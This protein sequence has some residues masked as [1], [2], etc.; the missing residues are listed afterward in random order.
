MDI[1]KIEDEARENIGKP[2]KKKT[3]ARSILLK[4]KN[5]KK[6]NVNDPNDVCNFDAPQAL[7]L[8]STCPPGAQCLS[9]HWEICAMHEIQGNGYNADGTL[10]SSL[11]GYPAPDTCNLPQASPGVFSYAIGWTT[12]PLT[13]EYCINFWGNPLGSNAPGYPA[14][15]YPVWINNTDGYGP[16]ADGLP[17]MLQHDFFYDWVVSQ[18]G[19]NLNY[20]TRIVF[21]VCHQQAAWPIP[22]GSGTTHPTSS[23]CGS[24]SLSLPG[25]N[26]NK[27][28]I[29]Y[30]G[31]KHWPGSGLTT[32]NNMTATAT[33]DP[34][35]CEYLSPP[36]SAITH[37]PYD[38]GDIGPGGGII[39]ALPNTGINNTS[40]AY[41]I[42]ADA[43]QLATTPMAALPLECRNQKLLT[44]KVR[45]LSA[46]IA[47]GLPNTALRF[48]YGPG[49]QNPNF[50][51]SD[52][53]IGDILNAF[54]ITGGSLFP[55]G[56]IPQ[57]TIITSIPPSPPLF[58]TTHCRIDFSVSMIGP[59]AS[60]PAASATFYTIPS[61]IPTT[62]AEWGGYDRPIIT[63]EAFG[64]GKKNTDI[65]SLITQTISPPSHPTVP[66][67]DIAADL[68]LAFSQNNLN[69]WFLPSYEELEEAFNVLGSNGLDMLPNPSGINDERT[70]YWSSSALNPVNNT[71]SPTTNSNEFA[72]SYITPFNTTFLYRKCKTLSV[73]PVRRFECEDRG[74]Q[75]DYRL[76]MSTGGTGEFQSGNNAANSNSPGVIN[77]M[78]DNQ[79]QSLTQTTTT[80]ETVKIIMT[81]NQGWPPSTTFPNGIGP[82]VIMVEFSAGA[83]INVGQ[84]L[85]PPL[86][87]WGPVM[88][89]Y[90]VTIVG[91][92][93]VL[94]AVFGNYAGGSSV[95]TSFVSGSFQSISWTNTIV[96]PN[97]NYVPSVFG[98]SNKEIGKE[99]L[100]IDLSAWDVRLNNLKSF[101]RWA[102][103]WINNDLIGIRPFVLF[104]IKVYNQFEELLGD[105][106]Y[107]LYPWE[108]SMCI[109]SYCQWELYGNLVNTNYVNPT[110]AHPIHTS[111]IDLTHLFNRPAGPDGPGGSILTS[112]GAPL[113][114]YHDTNTHDE[115]SGYVSIELL[116]TEYTHTF[117]G[118][119][120]NTYQYTYSN[121]NPPS[122]FNGR[123][124]TLNL[125]NWLGVGN[126]R[127]TDPNNPPPEWSTLRNRFPWGITCMPCGFNGVDGCI[128]FKK[129]EW[130]AELNYNSG[131]WIIPPGF[132]YPQYTS[133]G[134]PLGVDSCSN[135]G[136]TYHVSH[137]NGGSWGAAYIGETDATSWS[138]ATG[139]LNISNN[140]SDLSIG[141]AC[142]PASNP[143]KF[144]EIELTVENYKE[145]EGERADEQCFKTGS[146][147]YTLYIEDPNNITKKSA[148]QKHVNKV[149]K[150]KETGPFGIMGYYPLYD[151]IP[152][153]QL[154]SP[155]DLKTRKNENTIGY[156]IHV[157][158]NIEYYMPNGLEMGVTQFHGDYNG[159]IIEQP[160]VEQEVIEQQQEI[161]YVQPEQEIEEEE[162]TPQRPA[163]AP[164]PTPTPTYTPPSSSSGGG[165]SRGGGY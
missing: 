123:G 86:A 81:G 1:K 147:K 9:H 128:N 23:V 124:N 97:P 62:G 121:H 58:T 90:T 152:G 159:I 37:C 109:K 52:V 91:G 30:K 65:I 26:W 102:P 8:V 111:V 50:L 134:Y 17:N 142:N 74:I 36:T 165:S 21:D 98:N 41:E 49:S 114:Y 126:R 73:L 79:L 24:S 83:I 117:P 101:F 120:T 31:R 138:G 89:T 19:Q 55:A 29:I 70:I 160:K 13:V 144:K 6:I 127:I 158:G 27:L 72:W 153:A 44:V 122:F 150:P 78:G 113:S 34:V 63:S 99:Y 107:K 56:L 157:F 119:Q 106:D 71:L 96:T 5:S 11:N 125:I 93:T 32:I 16:G 76:A 18:V 149:K 135:G 139:N 129:R 148:R 88:F 25:Q 146:E 69:D 104:N 151:T 39:F 94:R 133:S 108:T 161:T 43:I 84:V 60:Q 155:I 80:T 2:K 22:V 45:Q 85:D 115:G 154:A 164:P 12:P 33:I 4:N 141:H 28:C 137:I 110:Y 75:Y 67:H 51:P 116:E 54:G 7:Q 46:A 143:V 131:L 15:Y 132:V 64:Q 47:G 57:V 66:S 103:N 140:W 53:S 82:G 87:F 48:E 38:I 118:G 40:F 3:T 20:G 92:I 130:M 42:S 61:N 95:S 145:I 77:F 35:C 156:H 59:P 162:I 136:L 68:T 112:S 163:P 14:S 100:R 10:W 105:W